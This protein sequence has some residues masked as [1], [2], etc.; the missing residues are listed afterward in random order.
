MVWVELPADLEFGCE[1]VG[2]A[3]ILDCA[4]RFAGTELYRHGFS[5]PGPLADAE[6]NLKED[7]SA[8]AEDDLT[9]RI[10]RPDH[11][12]EDPSAGAEDD[13]DNDAFDT[14]DGPDHQQEDPSAEAEDGPDND[15]MDTTAGPST[16]GPLCWSGG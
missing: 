15:A 10:P 7:P 3:C 14:T 4:S 11:Q 2:V 6:D 16:G 8:R 13:L 1:A 9:Q 5:S 12:Q